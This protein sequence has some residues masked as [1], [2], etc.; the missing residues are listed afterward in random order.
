MPDYAEV[1][2]NNTLV[3]F[4]YNYDT[5]QAEN[6]YTNF[7]PD[8]T[9]VEMFDGTTAN[10]EGNTLQTVT[11]A[12]EP[13]FDPATQ[14]CTLNTQPTLVNGQWTLEWTVTQ[15]TPQQQQAYQ[16]QVQANNK[17]QAKQLLTATDWT[18]IP[19]VTNTANNPHLTNQADFVTYRNQLRA[20]AVNPPTTPVTN[21]PVEPTEQWS[22]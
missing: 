6:P 21:W 2:S 9:L 5:L 4:P 10:L 11:T 3:K 15:M 12:P 20:I 1:S 7:P 18:E 14:I 8:K 16:Q 17:A 22:S 13:T 19:S